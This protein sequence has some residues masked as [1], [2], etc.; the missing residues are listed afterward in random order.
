M[1]PFPRARRHPRPVTQTTRATLLAALTTL[2][3]VLVTI[4]QTAAA[5]APDPA[6]SAP[7]IT[8][9]DA[10]LSSLVI[11]ADA[12]AGAQRL[13]LEG[14]DHGEFGAWRPRAVQRVHAPGPVT[15]ELPLQ[16]AAT[17][18]VEMF[19]V[20]ADTNDPLPA[21][22]YT[23]KVNHPAEPSAGG[24]PILFRGAD[25]SEWVVDTAIP[26]T[27]DAS[28]PQRT[29]AESDIWRLHRDRLYFFNHQRGLQIVDVSRTDAPTLLAT[30]PLP[31]S[32]EQMYLLDDRHVA[33]LARAQPCEDSWGQNARSAVVIIDVHNDSPREL[34][35][36]P[37]EGRILES[38]MVGSALYVASDTWTP[39]TDDDGSTAESV[40]VNGT[41]VLGINLANPGAPVAQPPLWLPGSGNVVAATERFLL[42]GVQPPD[43]RTWWQSRL[44]VLDIDDPAGA[45]RDFATLNLDG[46]LQDKFKLNVHGDILTAITAGPSQPDGA[47]AWRSVVTT[48]RLANPAAAAPLPAV[49]LASVEVGHGEQL[50][51][52]RFDGTRAYV[53][54]FLQIDPLWVIDLANPEQPRV[55]GELE[56]PGWSSYIHPMGDRLLT[57][58]FDN[59]T[60]LRAAVQLFD[61]ADPAK[62]SLLAKIPL[63]H[64]W[65]WS[66]A[67]SD[68]KALGVFPDQDLVLV[69]FSSNASSQ[70]ILG[71][72][73]IDLARDSLAARGTITNPDVVP[74][75]TAVSGDRVLAVSARDLVSVSL[76]DRDRPEIR[77][78]L[79]LAYPVD[80][81][82]PVGPWLIEISGTKVRTRAAATASEPV[83]LHDLSPLPVL[84]ATL[85][86]SHAF[87]LQGQGPETALNGDRWVT[88]APG[89]IVLTTLD[90][91]ALPQLTVAGSATHELPASVWGDF[92]PLWPSPDLL[93]WSP[94][95]HSMPWF[96]LPGGP[97]VID[98]IGTSDATGS[99]P[100]PVINA[101]PLVPIPEPASGPATVADASFAAPDVAILPGFGR[102]W[103]PPTQ[104]L[105]AFDVSNP[106]SPQAASV[107]SPPSNATATTRATAVPPDLIYLGFD[108]QEDRI[109]A[110]NT[111]VQIVR[112]RV[113]VQR[114]VQV[115]NVVQVPYETIV[116]NISAREFALPAW[117]LATPLLS[118]LSAGVLHAV[119]LDD[120]G[121]V[122]GWGD[123]RAGQLGSFALINTQSPV[124]LPFPS[125]A[126][127]AAAAKWFT[128]AR[129]ADGSVWMAGSPLGP[130]GPTIPNGQTPTTANPVQ[131][132]P[133]L[134]PDVSEI[135]VGYH[136]A[137]ARSSQGPVLS[138]GANSHGQLGNGDVLDAASPTPVALPAPA[139]RIA[140]GGLHSLALLADGSIAAWGDMQHA[141]STP[142]GPGH[143][144]LPHTVPAPTAF[145][146][147]AAGDHHAL[148]LDA[149]GTV[150][151]W[152]DALGHDAT[153][154][155]L[156]PVPVQGLPAI[157]SIAAGR[158]LS[159][160]IDAQGQA[161]SWG[162]HTPEPC[163]VL[164][165]EPV[166]T[167]A[168][169]G[170]YAIAN[171]VSGRTYLW[172]IE[173]YPTP[174]AGTRLA[175]TFLGTVRTN[176]AP[177]IAHRTETN[178]TTRT[179]TETKWVDSTVTNTYPV[180][181]YFT[182]HHLAV[183]DFSSNPAKPVSRPPVPIPGRFEGQSHAGALIFTTA[184]RSDPANPANT[185]TPTRQ[186]LEASAYDGVDAHLVAG[187]EI[188]NLTAGD[189]A[190]VRITPDGTVWVA[191]ST[192]PATTTTNTLAVLGL[193]PDGR[194]VQ[195]AST[196]LPAP[197]H[198]LDTLG[199][200]LTAWSGSNVRIFDWREDQAILPVGQPFDLGCLLPGLNRLAGDPTH[201]VWA[202]LGDFGSVR[203]P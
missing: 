46:R 199:D 190:T 174:Q 29:V 201:G 68:E 43:A 117:Q 77:A 184:T 134:P 198:S 73:V 98:F 48:Y 60:G 19:R 94:V 194:F 45:I 155:A 110:T 58:G 109:T 69:P 66:E 138:W 64:E 63:G 186:I 61:V 103:N 125:P 27:P 104:S 120:A 80:R 115:T 116:T 3:A 89:R 40:W 93:V 113:T 163:R 88:N 4:L 149:A 137:L 151:S 90:T 34:A 20:R 14:A 50:H 175:L 172:Q 78:R 44:H 99:T 31:G 7:R 136:H 15:F 160:A 161:W 70:Q 9:I 114:E 148:A 143:A 100:P 8:A 92:E 200:L 158:H 162:R 59:T 102:W 16:L 1:K 146:D 24:M 126:L 135:A 167:A 95:A 170:S 97:W 127:A 156:V 52:T 119:G 133:G 75:R 108:T 62:P 141:L 56:I 76:A 74:R 147:L 57:V 17:L 38:R 105:F 53:V 96:Y 10:S 37:I 179:L 121:R 123:N 166:R 124:T 6:H 85:H 193:N 82:L 182:H 188:A 122:L 65:S 169:R 178:V 2:A 72:Q 12:P 140:A 165:P 84:G 32:G 33:L 51:A 106:A 18:G 177:G 36:V 28:S 111:Y 26:T 131:P 157:R 164:I 171:G 176:I 83:A 173:D 128:L 101:I 142:Q 86:A 21:A 71:V 118:N 183:F 49:R 196:A 139:I 129:L 54:T 112:E 145:Q 107:V 132:V 150:W 67:T 180:H 159:V 41:R 192:S 11:T 168:A 42:V 55:L 81:V 87:I 130:D 30:F 195:H 197:A 47:G 25:G 13:V 189:S 203:L 153:P 91:S 144:A 185:P 191:K 181:E 154:P 152:G 39:R 22:F 202:P 5:N 79:E 23:G 187:L 35:R